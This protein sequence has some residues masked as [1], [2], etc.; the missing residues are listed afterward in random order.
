M[1]YVHS[2]PLNISRS[3]GATAPSRKPAARNGDEPPENTAADV[4]HVPGLRCEGEAA[5]EPEGS[6]YYYAERAYFT[7]LVLGC[8]EAEFQQAASFG[9]E[10]ILIWGARKLSLTT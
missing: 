4:G 1:R 6:V 2:S 8:I 10:F 5:E 7:G 9:S 3:S